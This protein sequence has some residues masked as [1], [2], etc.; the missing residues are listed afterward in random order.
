MF[1]KTFFEL[2]DQVFAKPFCV[3]K[4]QVFLKVFY[5]LKDQVFVK[6][7]YVFI[8]NLSMAQYR[9]LSTG[10][11]VSHQFSTPSFP[12]RNLPITAEETI[13]FYRERSII[14]TYRKGYTLQLVQHETKGDQDNDL[15]K[16]YLPATKGYYTIR[17]KLCFQ[18]NLPLSSTLEILYYLSLDCESSSVAALMGLVN[19]KRDS[20][21]INNA[22]ITRIRSNEFI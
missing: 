9:D 10:L 6:G 21:D 17:P 2:K 22:P 14:P 13:L 8:H 16:Y 7:L 5:G 15:W 12:R 20:K 18:D 19:H 1:S 11:F 4:D 3:L